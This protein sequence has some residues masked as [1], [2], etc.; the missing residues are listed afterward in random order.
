[1]SSSRSTREREIADRDQH[2]AALL[3]P[4]IRKPAVHRHRLR[5]VFGQV[6]RRELAVAAQ[7]VR[8]RAMAE[9]SRRRSPRSSQLTMRVEQ[10][11]LAGVR[12][13][14]ARIG[15]VAFT[16]CTDGD[17]QPARAAQDHGAGAARGQQFEQRQRAQ[18]GI[19]RAQLL[20][21]GD[22]R[23][24]FPRRP[25]ASISSGR[26]GL[27]GPRRGPR[28]SATPADSAQ[29]PL[30]GQ[31]LRRD[32][33]VGDQQHVA[34]RARAPARRLRESGREARV[35][36][37]ERG[38]G[39]HAADADAPVAAGGV[40]HGVVEVGGRDDA[41]LSAPARRRSGAAPPCR[42]R[43]WR[44]PTRARARRRRAPSRRLRPR[45]TPGAP[46]AVARRRSLGGSSAGAYG[47]S[48]VGDVGGRAAQNGERRGPAGK[49]GRRDADG[50]DDDS[51]LTAPA[52][53]NTLQFVPPKPKEFDNAY[54]TGAR[55]RASSTPA[56]SAGSC[57][58]VLRLRGMKPCSIASRQIA[59][60]TMPAAPSVWPVQPFV[61]LHGTA[62]PNSALTA[63]SSAASFAGV[64]VPCR[65]M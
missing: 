34:R 54:S 22:S 15:C 42:H 56:C 36:G 43:S 52:P 41:W 55:A 10:A 47:V 31:R 49:P 5:A 19:A 21:R 48:A 44:I 57:S 13:Q 62:A 14:R 45:E 30:R 23:R 60:S 8:R 65:L 9:T 39:R 59:A 40:V 26:A 18:R 11:H 12:H 7:R 24:A 4:R 2:A 17:E 63:A 64:A 27:P 25:R 28:I 61:E 3:R 20:E 58:R 38:R 51:A 46:T 1:M 35:V 16:A 53:N 33:V 29:R 50:L 32:R 37:R 6:Q